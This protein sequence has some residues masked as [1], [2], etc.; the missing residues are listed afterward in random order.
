M[1]MAQ[2]DRSNSSPHKR[3]LDW[4][5]PSSKWEQDEYGALP[6]ASEPYDWTLKDGEIRPTQVIPITSPVR[7][8]STKLRW[9]KRKA[10][11]SESSATI[12]LEKSSTG[13]IFSRRIT[14]LLRPATTRPLVESDRTRPLVEGDRTRP[15]VEID[16]IKAPRKAPGW[17]L[18]LLLLAVIALFVFA[19]IAQK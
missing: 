11:V 1:E 9:L 5:N 6:A 15:L 13:K 4:L 16:G 3:A 12:K 18:P 7:R 19:Y 10:N 2:P 17:A 8:S 14:R